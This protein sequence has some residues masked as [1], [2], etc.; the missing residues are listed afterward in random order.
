MQPFVQVDL[1]TYLDTV[2]IKTSFKKIL[3]LTAVR[4]ILIISARSESY[5]SLEFVSNPKVGFCKLYRLPMEIGL[6]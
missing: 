5:C 1:L 6:K 3:H 2:F 4:Y